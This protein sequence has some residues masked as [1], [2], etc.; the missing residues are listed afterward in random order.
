MTLPESGKEEFILTAGTY[1]YEYDPARDY[2]KVLS[3][4]TTLHDLKAFPEAL[5]ILQK[6]LPSLYGIALA[7]DPEFSFVPLPVLKNFG[8]LG[9]E[10][11]AFE[12]AIQELG[13]LTWYPEG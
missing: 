10:P 6:H 4:G 7:E 3:E 12:K 5:E 1:D 13:D 11:A 2:R 9:I 8:F